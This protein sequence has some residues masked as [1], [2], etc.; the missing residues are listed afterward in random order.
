MKTEPSLLRRAFVVL[1]LVLPAGLQC[2]RSKCESLR[3]ELTAQKEGWAQCQEDTDCVLVG[4]SGKDCTGI[5]SCD[6]PVN[7]AFRAEAER[8]VASL[9][10]ETVDCMECSAPKCVG[11]SIVVCDPTS[12][13]CIPVTEVL[14]SGSSAPVPTEPT[15]TGGQGASTSSGTG[16]QS[17]TELE[18]SGTGGSS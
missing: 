18:A 6:F 15:G 8:R 13:Q 3:D 14:D 7:R 10:E 2:N 4:G 12:H 5:M 11:G 1:A 16:G 17:G 9:P